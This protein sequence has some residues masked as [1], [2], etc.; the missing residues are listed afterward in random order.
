MKRLA[1]AGS[2]ALLFALAALSCAGKDPIVGTWGGKSVFGEDLVLTFSKDGKITV[3]FPKGGTVNPGKYWL[4][5]TTTPIGF[6]YELEGRGRIKT[7]LEFVDSDTLAFE[8][9]GSSSDPRPTGFGRHRLEFK[10]R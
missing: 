5:R 4:D 7:I 9:V 10:R 3:T 6:D 1:A 2:I 8:E